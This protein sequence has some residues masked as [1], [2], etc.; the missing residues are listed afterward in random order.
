M[1]KELARARI[2]ELKKTIN[3]HN[4]RYY[5]LDDPVIS[6][7]E[8]DGLMRELSDLERRFPEFLTADSPTQRV[9]GEPLPSFRKVV[10]RLP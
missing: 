1:D 9:G 4:H 2:E 7:A 5:V 3:F 6:D 10:H 8:Y